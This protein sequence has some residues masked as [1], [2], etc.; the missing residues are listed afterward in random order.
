MLSDFITSQIRT[1]VPVAIGALISWGVLPED[2]SES[3]ALAA[4][5]AVIGVYYLVVRVLEEKVHPFF[6]WLLGKATPEGTPTYTPP[7]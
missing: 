4:T 2:M 1:W 5:A 3:A 6:G 7:S